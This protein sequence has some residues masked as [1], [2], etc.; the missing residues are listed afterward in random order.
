M[1]TISDYE[2]LQHYKDRRPPWIKL[3]RTLL[4]SKTW[5]SLSD[6]P[7][8]L[9]VELWLLASEHDKKGTI[10]LDI[11]AI[12]WRLRYASNSL[13]K[14]QKAMQELEA[15]GYLTIDSEPLAPCQQSAIPETE[16]EKRQRTEGEKEGVVFSSPE[17]DEAWERWE[18]YRREIKKALK[19]STRKAQLAKLAA[20]GE[21]CAIIAI[22]TSI[23]NGWTGLFPPRTD[24][25]Q[26]PQET[27]PGLLDYAKQYNT[28]VEEQPDDD[29]FSRLFKK[30]K[31]NYGSN[32]V[33]RMK[34]AAEQL[35]GE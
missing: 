18:A 16:R 25:H 15:K 5:R 34:R 8:R 2:N 3:Y 14:I 32:G 10:D 26:P 23:E 4:D 31:D 11:E 12:A 9:L 30:A 19:P 21:D 6:L 13:A 35:K 7:A 29:S 28:L 24:D 20:W 17:M 22:N 27:D 1:I 33:E